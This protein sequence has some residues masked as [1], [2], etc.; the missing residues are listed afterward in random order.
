LPPNTPFED[1]PLIR[2]RHTLPPPATLATPQPPRGL[3]RIATPLPRTLRA[4]SYG[5][6]CFEI[7]RH[8]FAI[9]Y[10]AYASAAAVL[11]MPLLMLR[12]VTPPRLSAIDIITPATL[13]I[14]RR[15]M[16]MLTPASRHLRHT[17][18]QPPESAGFARR[19]AIDMAITL[20]LMGG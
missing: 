12:Y 9:I 3:R 1:T 6:Y 10:D 17:P 15:Q 4:A 7:L 2:C 18:L 14:L 11:L 5:A 8:V 20:R 19:R 13:L 16:V